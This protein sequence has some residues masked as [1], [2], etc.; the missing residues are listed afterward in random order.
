MHR[1]KE[2]AAADMPSA[3]H[4]SLHWE[5]A[6][7]VASIRIQ[8]LIAY[9]AIGLFAS[10]GNTVRA[11]F[12]GGDQRAE[13]AGLAVP[14]GEGLIGW[15]ADVG[16]PILNGNPAVEPGYAKGDRAPVLSSALALPLVN[17]GSVIGVVA[18]YRKEK[19]AFAADELVSLLELCPAL[20]SLILE[21]DEQTTNLVE[22][23]TALQNDSASLF[24]VSANLPPAA[25][26]L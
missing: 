25:G 6:L 22:M 4:C 23:A 17:S 10:D 1:K 18:L 7:V 5:E 9:D 2:E 8:R 11:K 19:D 3:G 13:L 26:L 21:S 14:R 16:K 20:A 15:V 12:T 24:R